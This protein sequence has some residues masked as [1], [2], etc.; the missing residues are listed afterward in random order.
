MPTAKWFGASLLA[1]ISPDLPLLR[2]V[3]TMRPSTYSTTH[4][5]RAFGLDATQLANLAARLPVGSVSY[6][7]NRRQH[8]SAAA[9]E[10]LIAGNDAAMLAEFRRRLDLV[11][12]PHVGP[13]DAQSAA[14]AQFRH[15]VS[16]RRA[17]L[18]V[19]PPPPGRADDIAAAKANARAYRKG[20]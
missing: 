4:V 11:A 12:P 10:T 14:A 19:V 1:A 18:A 17:G 2:K 7:D 6:D 9:L 5:T 13:T 3:H 15:N 16:T 20:R 8:L